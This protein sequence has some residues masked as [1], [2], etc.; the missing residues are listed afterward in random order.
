[1]CMHMDLLYSFVTMQQDVWHYAGVD[2]CVGMDCL[3]AAD[4]YTGPGCVTFAVGTWMKLIEEVDREGNV[5]KTEFTEDRLNSF[6]TSGY[7]VD[8][9]YIIRFRNLVDV[10][11]SLESFIKLTCSEDEMQIST[12]SAVALVNAHYNWRHSRG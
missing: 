2:I 4:A 6:K 9:Q 1:M 5:G 12:P 10:S 11:Y 8:S 3:T 7:F